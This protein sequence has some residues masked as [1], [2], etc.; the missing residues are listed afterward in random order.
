MWTVMKC[1][2]YQS[3]RGLLQGVVTWKAEVAEQDLL[4]FKVKLICFVDT[5][6]MLTSINIKPA[7]LLSLLKQTQAL[8]RSIMLTVH[9]GRVCDCELWGINTP[10]LSPWGEMLK[11]LLTDG[12]SSFKH[13]QVFSLEIQSGQCSHPPA[14]YKS[15]VTLFAARQC[16]GLYYSFSIAS[17][18][19]LC[20][21]CE[22]TQELLEATL[23]CGLTPTLHLLLL[24]RAL[25]SRSNANVGLVCSW[26]GTIFPLQI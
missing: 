12:R 6:M 24:S 7:L 16:T 22:L 19:T 14:I 20:S 2:S 1:A 26:L 4:H 8:A 5:L 23:M 25:H 10:A 3:I 21:Q 11:T 9:E 13:K 18:E 17:T 15:L